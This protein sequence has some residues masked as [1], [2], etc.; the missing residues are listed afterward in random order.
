MTG[1]CGV[2][3]SAGRRADRTGRRG[4]GRRRARRCCQ[5]TG[6]RCCRPTGQSCS[7]RTPPGRRRRNRSS[8]NASP[9]EGGRVVVGPRVRSVVT[10]P[11]SSGG[12]RALRCPSR[13]GEGQPS[14]DALSSD[15]ASCVVHRV[16]TTGPGWSRSSIRTYGPLGAARVALVDANA[17]DT[18]ATS[19]GVFEPGAYQRGASATSALA[20]MV[21]SLT[22]DSVSV[23]TTVASDPTVTPSWYRYS[24]AGRQSPPSRVYTS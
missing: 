9:F 13:S 10:D 2:V 14:P 17:K 19:R 8:V 20:E 24:P 22:T 4:R 6:R 11:P 23:R 16:S 1:S 7:R 21:P 3:T 18:A 5:P 12:S 15:A